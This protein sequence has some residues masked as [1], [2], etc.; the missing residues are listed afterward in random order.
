MEKV[1]RI[2]SAMNQSAKA[3][4][5]S[6]WRIAVESWLQSKSF[7]N[8][9]IN[10]KCHPILSPFSLILITIFRYWFSTAI[11]FGAA[12]EFQIHKGLWF[13]IGHIRQFLHH[14]QLSSA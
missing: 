2:L 3:I 7:T 14:I 10:Q 13:G 9:R 4:R 6:A 1:E 12:S 5:E 8:I 11:V